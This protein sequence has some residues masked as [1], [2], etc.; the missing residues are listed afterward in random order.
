[1]NNVTNSKEIQVGAISVVVRELT[2]L[3]VRAWLSEISEARKDGF[4][5]V[6]EA[7]FEECSIND[8]KR[9]TSLTEDQVNS[10]RPSQLREVIALC[11]ELNPDFF[12]FMGRLLQAPKASA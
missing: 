11:K 4:D 6:D 3:Q 2:V 12:G 1:M 8:I 10:L 5:P 7:F 9:M